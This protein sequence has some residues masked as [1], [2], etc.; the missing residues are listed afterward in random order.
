MFLLILAWQQLFFFLANSFCFGEH[1]FVI[2][3]VKISSLVA[4]FIFLGHKKVRNSKHQQ[5]QHCKHN[6]FTQDRNKISYKLLWKPEVLCSES[7][8]PLLLLQADIFSHLQWHYKDRMTGTFWWLDGIF[9]MQTTITCKE[10][11]TIW[12]CSFL[13]SSCMSNCLVVSCSCCSWFCCSFM[14]SISWSCCCC[15]AVIWRST[16]LISC[17]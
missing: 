8:L 7:Y 10:C 12:R 16:D 1:P 17:K 5:M 14:F 6:V 13:S 3:K 4:V 15:T 9:F 11:R 2:F